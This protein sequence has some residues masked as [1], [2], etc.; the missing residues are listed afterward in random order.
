M[1]EQMIIFTDLDGTLLDAQD[2]SFA[3]AQPA[4]RAA[5]ER[6]VP[7]IFC[8]SKTRAEMEVIQAECGLTAPFIV[9]N[10]GAIFI[11]AQY[12]P[13]PLT[14]AKAAGDYRVLELGASYTEVVAAFR[15]LRME[16]A[17]QMTGFSDL[18]SGE[19]AADCGLSLSAA[20]HAKAREYSEPFRFDETDLTKI[21]AALQH[22][23]QSGWRF[24]IGGR[25]HHLHGNTDKGLA[26]QRLCELFQQQYD[27]IFT[28]GLGDSLND[29][30]MLR[31]VDLPV[32]VRRPSG[33]LYPE[34][35]VEIPH[36]RPTQNIGPAGWCEA[37]L[38]ILEERR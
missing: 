5:Q 29:L 9:E 15:R 38:E 22:I 18:T 4:L 2:Y 3:A 10:G 36:V 28:V 27:T 7:I 31:A 11:P 14:A 30:P 34:V 25:Y 23:V 1:A 6:G 21:E 37:V 16:T 33:L 12:F 19:I 17:C 26:V 24:S 20:K 35:V 8:S 32:L 13:F